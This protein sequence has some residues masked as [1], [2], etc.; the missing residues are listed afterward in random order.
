MKKL[1]LTT[2]LLFPALP[3]TAQE[4]P[5]FDARGHCVGYAEDLWAKGYRADYPGMLRGGFQN[6]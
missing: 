2:F 5:S 6:S 4:M 1:L 3:A